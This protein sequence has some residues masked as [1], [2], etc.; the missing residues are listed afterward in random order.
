MSI[1]QAYAF[2]QVLPFVAPTGITPADLKH[3]TGDWRAKDGP[4]KR[5]LECSALEA[6]GP[7]R[8]PDDA[9]GGRGL[10]ALMNPPRAYE[11]AARL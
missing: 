1:E 7:T 3:E 4:Q 11:P 8:G 9:Q 5:F 10:R 6:C 2:K